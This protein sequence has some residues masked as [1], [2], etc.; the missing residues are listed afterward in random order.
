MKG[1]IMQPLY[2]LKEHRNKRGLTQH[3]L[4]TLSGVSRPTIARL[5]TT[6]TRA[7]PETARKLAR[8]LKVKPEALV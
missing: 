2:R 6:S 8:A 3:E 7:T 1:C 5:E 4:A